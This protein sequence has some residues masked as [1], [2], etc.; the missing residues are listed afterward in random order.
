MQSDDDF[1]QAKGWALPG[2]VRNIAV[3]APTDDVQRAPA[4][5]TVMA[6]P[7]FSSPV[8]VTPFW[9]R[10]VRQ[11]IDQHARQ[12]VREHDSRGSHDD[13]A[14]TG[15]DDNA[16]CIRPDLT[17]T[18]RSAEHCIAH[19]SAARAVRS[20]HHSGSGRRGKRSA[21]REVRMKRPLWRPSAASASL[22][23]GAR[24]PS[25]AGPIFPRRR[26]RSA[27]THQLLTVT[28]PPAALTC[29]S[30]TISFKPRARPQ[31]IVHGDIAIFGPCPAMARM[32]CR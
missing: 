32:R 23:C 14:G 25:C 18:R 24:R 19:C 12:L 21:P 9:D 20:H 8:G 6:A 30:R 11:F 15:G 5:C 31:V 26:S 1:N 17:A 3:A 13:G 16:S 27:T 7:M 28:H 2:W 22:V 10:P 4:G 29:R